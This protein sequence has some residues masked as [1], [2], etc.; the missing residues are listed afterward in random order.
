MMDRPPSAG[1]RRFSSAAARAA[2][3]LAPVSP[4]KDHEGTGVSIH[5]PVIGET[6]HAADVSATTVLVAI[7]SRRAGAGGAC[8]SALALAVPV[9]QQIATAA[10]MTN[11]PA[12][13]AAR[14]A[15]DDSLGAYVMFGKS[16]VIYRHM[17]DI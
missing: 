11:R 9:R 13:S 15:A 14:W 6:M 1:C 8:P 4:A 16:S 17:G 5:R 3:T 7:A 12:D 2:A 10:P